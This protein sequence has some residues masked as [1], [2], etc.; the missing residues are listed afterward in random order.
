MQSAA[1]ISTVECRESTLNALFGH[2]PFPSGRALGAKFYS[3]EESESMRAKFRLWVVVG[4]TSTRLTLTA[5]VGKPPNAKDPRM[6]AHGY[7]RPF[8]T[9]RTP[10]A[11]PPAPD[12]RTLNFRS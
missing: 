1:R 9:S 7:K 3:E 11:E 2:G 4:A 5:L 8:G 6:A 10:S 12:I